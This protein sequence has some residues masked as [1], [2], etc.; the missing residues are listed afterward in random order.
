MN[1]LFTGIFLG[2]VLIVWGLSLLVE[3]IFGINIPVIKI[4]FACL[5]IYTGI[6]LVKGIYDSQAQKSIV[7]SQE[8]VKPGK[9]TVQNYY[10]VIFGQGII[11]LS[12]IVDDSSDLVNVQIYTL[13]GKTTLKMNPA[14]PTAV[15]ATSVFSSVTFPDKTLISLGNYHYQTGPSDQKPKVLVDAT[16]VFSALEVK[17]S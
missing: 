3:T 15:N 10:K 14:V 5:L 1:F 17:N 2:T 16:A 7:F 11:D 6:V 4:G 8:R 13:C 12:E 9:T